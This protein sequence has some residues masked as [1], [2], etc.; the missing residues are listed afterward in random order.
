[1]RLEVAAQRLGALAETDDPVLDGRQLL[2]ASRAGAP[3]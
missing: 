3:P 2:P 1:L